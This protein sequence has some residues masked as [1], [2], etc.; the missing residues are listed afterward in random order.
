M[1]VEFEFDDRLVQV[2]FGAGGSVSRI[3]IARHNGA[4]LTGGDLR[5]FRWSGAIDEARQ[6][7]DATANHSKLGRLSDPPPAFRESRQGRPARTDADYA[8][9]A[10]CWVALPEDMR[11]NAASDWSARFGRSAQRWR[12]DIA[13]A[14]RFV[15]GNAGSEWLTDEAQELAYGPDVFDRIAVDVAI[16]RAQDILR[17]EGGEWLR[18]AVQ[19]LASRHKVS[20]ARA[21]A[22]IQQSARKAVDA[23][24]GSSNG[25]H[26]ADPSTPTSG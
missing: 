13:R 12:M 22:H 23:F 24:Y 7:A 1:S 18:G 8:E 16:E 21:L 11:R 20:E 6:R 26:S 15:T 5:R 3:S 2:E 17:G 10:R 14:R 19:N 25:A 9:L 4:S